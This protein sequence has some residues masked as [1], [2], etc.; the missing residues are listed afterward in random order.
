MIFFL[1][2]TGFVYEVAKDYPGS[3]S[4]SQ[5]WIKNCKYEGMIT[6]FYADCFQ[7]QD[8]FGVKWISKNRDDELRVYADITH[9]KKPFVSYGMMLDDRYILTNVT[10]VREGSYIYLGYSNVRHGLMC[11]SN[12]LLTGVCWW[13]A[14]DILPLLNETSLIYSNGGAQV[15]Y[16]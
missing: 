4:I 13:N 7:E 14:T 15:Y 6:A 10:E 16:Q 5:N 12:P 9:Y 11:G 3:I 2:N 8:I 1:F